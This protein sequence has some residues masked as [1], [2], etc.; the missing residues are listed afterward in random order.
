VLGLAVLLT[1]G[2]PLAELAFGGR[3]VPFRY[4]APDAFY[5]HTVA[6][7]IAERGAIS[8][9]GT[10][11]TNGFHPL[12]QA[13]LA[14]LYRGTMAVGAGEVAYLNGA[15]LLGVLLVGAAVFVAGAAVLRSGRL[16]GARF[17]LLPVGAYALLVLPAWVL[18]TD[19]KGLSIASQGPHPLFGTMWAYVNGMESG[20]V[21]LAF[22]A[23]AW[24]FVGREAAPARSAL[25][26]GLL[27]AALTM[28]RLDHILLA[29]AFPGWYLLRARRERTPEALRELLLCG[30]GLALPVLLYLLFNLWYAGALLPVSGALKSSFP[31]PTLD[32]ARNALAVLNA[33]FADNLAVS[34]FY[35]AAQLIVPGLVAVGVLVAARWSRRLDRAPSGDAFD[36]FL[37]IAAVGVLALHGYDFLFVRAFDM[38]HWYVPASVLFVS[39][40]ALA[41]AQLGAERGPVALRFAVAV[42]VVIAA[43]RFGHYRPDY[44][45]MLARYYYAEAPALRAH[46]AG[47]E[48]RLVEYDDGIIAF[49]TRFPAL[50]GLG[51][52]LDPEAAA[53][54]RRGRMAELAR[55]RGFDRA[56]SLVYYYP[57]NDPPAPGPVAAQVRI[58]VFQRGHRRS[59]YEV[60][61]LSPSGEAWVLR[62]FPPDP[63]PTPPPGSDP[64]GG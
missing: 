1:V 51:L 37:R 24:V 43:F 3:G 22:A 48:P 50:S 20:L 38:G 10:Y 16:L 45:A 26:L 44:H 64:P 17:L 23:L 40:V 12:W 57:W 42:A 55:E 58:K 2:F 60:D 62:A 39:L 6:R 19:V 53:A 14:L 35:R 54:Y 5:Y 8:F 33:P 41:P 25:L 59:R 27:G 63:A 11:P 7:N 21:L 29:A 61:Y 9:D 47:R 31:R 30:A 36:L 15:I 28:A 49:S 13:V 56:A 34:R 32:N 4:F 46:Y 52:M 18:M